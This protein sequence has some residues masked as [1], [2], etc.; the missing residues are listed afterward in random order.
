MDPIACNYNPAAEENDPDNPCVYVED[1]FPDQVIDDVAYV[2]CSGN[3]LNDINNDGICD[4][5][6]PWGCTNPSS[7]NFDPIAVNDDGSCVNVCCGVSA[8]LCYPETMELP[9]PD[10]YNTGIQ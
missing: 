7:P 9:S 1:L 6:Q 8:M 5:E 10:N 3:C 2:D 4:E